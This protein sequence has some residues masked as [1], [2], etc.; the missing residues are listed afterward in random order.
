MPNFLHILA[1]HNNLHGI[2]ATHSELKKTA[3]RMEKLHAAQEALQGQID[4]DKFI[5]D[6]SDDTGEIACGFK[7]NP[8]TQTNHANA[9]R[10][11]G[12]AA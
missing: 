10:R 8:F 6:Y 11:I 2:T 5:L 12:V 3:R 4:A 9:A 1:T 7:D